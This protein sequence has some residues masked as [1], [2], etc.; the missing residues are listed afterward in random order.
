MI[1]ELIETYDLLKEPKLLLSIL[2]EITRLTNDEFPEKKEILR[3]LELKK[4]CPVEFTREG[5]IFLCTDDFKCERITEKF[6]KDMI[7]KAKLYI[8]K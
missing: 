7:K 6:V 4:T 2:Y 5:D 8:D 3:L 1:D